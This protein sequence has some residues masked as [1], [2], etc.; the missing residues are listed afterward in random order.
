MKKRPSTTA[1]LK[2]LAK[3]IA[4][5]VYGLESIASHEA[6]ADAA[7]R[8][9]MVDALLRLKKAMIDT[10]LLE[11]DLRDRL[12]QRKGRNGNS[13]KAGLTPEALEEIGRLLGLA[14]SE[15]VGRTAASLR[16]DD[17]LGD[18]VNN[19]FGDKVPDEA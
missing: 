1:H 5:L 2:F 3:H 14:K 16:Q 15:L 6:P 17:K 19:E 9:K 8:L 4:E 7:S 10:R 11:E 12:Q 18:K 13:R